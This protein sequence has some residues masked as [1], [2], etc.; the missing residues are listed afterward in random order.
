MIAVAKLL[1]RIQN[2]NHKWSVGFQRVFDTPLHLLDETYVDRVSALEQATPANG[3]VVDLGAGRGPAL[4]STLDESRGIRA[5]VVAIDIDYNALASNMHADFRVVADL[6][7]GIP[8]KSSCAD[9]VVSRA[10][11]EH[12]ERTEEFAREISRVLKPAGETLHFL[13]CGRAPFAVINRVIP[14]KVSQALLY[15][16]YPGAQDIAGYRAFYNDCNP[17]AIRTLFGRHGLIVTRVER[18]YY[19]SHYFTFLFPVYALMAFYDWVLWRVRADNYCASF[20][21]QATKTGS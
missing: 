11:I 20:I 10:V 9:Y 19:Q 18:S 16:L 21:V 14:H 12:L 1:A 4:N 8:L 17:A 5:K 2:A 13:P 15:A 3:L 7:S 6:T